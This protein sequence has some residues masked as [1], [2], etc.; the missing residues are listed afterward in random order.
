MMPLHE[1]EEGAEIKRLRA[2]LA[3]IEKIANNS[4]SQTKRIRII[5]ARCRSA[6]N[7][8]NEWRN[9][10]MPRKSHPVATPEDAAP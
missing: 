9:L 2:H 5:A 6:L 3:G 7:G 8:D 10:P 1:T 4:R